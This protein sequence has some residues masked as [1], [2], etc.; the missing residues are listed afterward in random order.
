[1]SATR[2]HRE[3]KA[4]ASIGPALLRV[5][6][7]LV[8]TALLLVTIGL[9]GSF[10][11]AQMAQRGTAG[12]V[13]GLVSGVYF[14]GLATGSFGAN[15]L[16][17]R[18]GHVRTFTALSAIMASSVLGIALSTHLMMWLVAR[19]AIGAAMGGLYVVIESWLTLASDS[20]QRGR[21]LAVY[22]MAVYGGLALGQLLLAV[23]DPSG[24][25]RLMMA[26]AS[27]CLAAVPVA[28][29]RSEVPPIV[30]PRSLEF[31]TMTRLAS[32]GLF[33]SGVAGVTNGAIYGVAPAMA[34]GLGYDDAQ[35]VLIMLAFV[36][37]GVV[38][39][40]P[41]GKASDVLDRR[42]VISGAA[43]L[44][45]AAAASG[46]WAHGLWPMMLVATALGA[47]LFSLYPV[48]VAYTFDR[49]APGDVLAA[50]TALLMVYFVAS[51]L[52]AVASASALEAFGQTGFF[53][54]VGIGAASLVAY[55]LFRAGADDSI[56]DDHKQHAFVV[57]R[58]SPLAGELDPRISEQ[59]H[60]LIDPLSEARTE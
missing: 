2:N 51:A 7:L 54:T 19:F 23:P 26:A 37:G 57:P 20:E 52:G 43:T 6:A 10:V 53:A 34:E 9:V 4:S 16:L 1:M 22:Q 5:A 3:G 27:V 38:F 24:T 35:V 11:P 60:T 49:V 33:C 50:S 31:R 40:W 17:A 21:V 29:S 46:M 15:V 18:V 41:V 12:W 13:I 36:L 48:A 42:L 39:Q 14:V 56:A 28:L 58:T 55:S 44:G 8:G 45:T 32:L 59:D 47:T 25:R 30:I